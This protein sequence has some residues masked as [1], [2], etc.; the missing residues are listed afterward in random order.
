MPDPDPANIRAFATPNE[1]GLWLG[2]N[3]ASATE[4]WVQI[5]RKCSGISG[6]TWDDVVVEALCWGWIDGV[7]KSLDEQSY[8]QRITPRRAKS[9]WSRRNTE[10]AERLL[11]EGRMQEPGLVH[12]RA[13]RADGR[14]ENAYKASAIAVPADFLTALESRPKASRFFASLTKSGRYVIAQGLLSAKRP[15]TRQRRFNKYLAQLEREENPQ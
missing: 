15:D 4:L 13:A 12:I 8:V 1:L 3:H 10:H 14:W 6:V 5:F 9:N 11:S 7:K 2:E